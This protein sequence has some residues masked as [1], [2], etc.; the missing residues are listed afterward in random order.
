MELQE[1]GVSHIQVVPENGHTD[2]RLWIFTTATRSRPE[3]TEVGTRRFKDKN[4]VM[5]KCLSTK[6]VT[7]IASCLALSQASIP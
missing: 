7:H 1:A 2:F 4:Q 3:D 5:R 6:L